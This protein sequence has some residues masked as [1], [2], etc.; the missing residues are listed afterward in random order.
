MT[1]TTTDYLIIGG[2]VW[3]WWTCFALQVGHRWGREMEIARL[4][5]GALTPEEFQ[6]IC[7]NRHDRPGCTRQDFEAGCRE[8][9]RKLFGP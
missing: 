3:L 8:Y 6:A 4:K 7:H 2:L 9:Q 1:M 5:R